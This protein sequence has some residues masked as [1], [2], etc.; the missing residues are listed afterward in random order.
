MSK[1]TKIDKANMLHQMGYC[2][3]IRNGTVLVRN[4]GGTIYRINPATLTCSC[5]ASTI[6]C[7][8]LGLA[9]LLCWTAMGID[10]TTADCRSGHAYTALGYERRR[11]AVE[12]YCLASVLR[13]R[14]EMMMEHKEAA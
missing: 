6:C 12:M 13:N 9:D 8:I 3:A 7:H 5:P 11:R 14:V 4:P 2:A 10:D 1:L